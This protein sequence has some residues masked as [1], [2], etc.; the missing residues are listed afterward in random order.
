[1]GRPQDIRDSLAGWLST[2]PWDYFVTLTFK[3]PKRT[4]ALAMVPRWVERAIFP[5]PLV[6]GLGWFAEEFH[7]DGE[8]L[9]IHG[10][11]YT[12][13]M[14]KWTRLAKGWH[15]TGRCKIETHDATRGAVDYCAK[16]VSKDAVGIADW[17]MFEWCEGARV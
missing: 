1:V 12:D 4:D 8:R 5:L 7:R 16:Y 17:R 15:K 13:P 2:M 9:H 10:L 3:R 14:A 11:L 6:Y